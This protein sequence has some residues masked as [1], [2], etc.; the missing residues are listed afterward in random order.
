MAGGLA[1]GGTAGVGVSSTTLVKS[2]NVLAYVGQDGEIAAHGSAGLAV[3]AGQT[4]NLT[5]VAVAG[6][7][8]G[9][10]GV[11]GSAVVNVITQETK[12]Y[13]DQGTIVDATSTVAGMAGVA[14]GV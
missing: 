7:G 2:T 9:E 14:L 4:E 10:A 8:A 13:I 5:T 1:F 6:A 12:A 11:A 3:S